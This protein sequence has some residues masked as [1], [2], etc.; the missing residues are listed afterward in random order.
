MKAYN[1]KTSATIKLG[2]GQE[3][4][5]PLYFV[6][7]TNDIKKEWE[8][9]KKGAQV[10]SMSD[11]YNA[12]VVGEYYR[13]SANKATSFLGIK[14]AENSIVEVTDFTDSS[15]SI[16]YT[17]KYGERD[18]ASIGYGHLY[19]DDRR[20]VVDKFMADLTYTK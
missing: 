12:E 14:F 8:R 7:H 15:L 2:N 10:E 13:V 4:Y 18:Y 3:V 5:A 6:V 9:I 1:V 11:R 17:N 19:E 16:Y 20:D